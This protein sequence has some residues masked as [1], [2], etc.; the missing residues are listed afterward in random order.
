M[1]VPVSFVLT[2]T[3]KPAV[4]WLLPVLLFDTAVCV[5]SIWAYRPTYVYSA[6]VVVQLSERSPRTCSRE[7]AGSNT[8]ARY[9]KC[10]KMESS[11]FELAIYI[12]IDTF[13]LM[14]MSHFMNRLILRG[15]SDWRT[16]GRTGGR[17]DGRTDTH[18]I[19][20]RTP[21]HKAF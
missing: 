6:A 9:A 12:Q 8:R 4:Y 7:D 21:Q 15:I 14:F 5:L 11:T 16:D 18:T 20:A 19:V 10:E 1:K 17:T 13:K 2:V 3:I